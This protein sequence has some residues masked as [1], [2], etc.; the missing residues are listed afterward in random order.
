LE[1]LVESRLAATLEALGEAVTIQSADGRSIYANRTALDLLKLSS[2]DELVGTAPGVISQ[3][4]EI[5]REDGTPIDA[6]QFPGNRALRGEE[7]PPLLV[8]NVVRATGE[9]RW[10][11]NKATVLRDPEDRVEMVVNLIENVTASKLT[12]RRAKFLAQAG[13]TL[14]SS[15][16]YKQTLENVAGSRCPRSPIGAPWI[17]STATAS[18]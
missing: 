1:T 4:F 15:L 5:Q 6:S 10:L 3:R 7:H 17:S 11:L 13:E 2:L 9:E 14:A 12:E 8:R 16:D 18:R